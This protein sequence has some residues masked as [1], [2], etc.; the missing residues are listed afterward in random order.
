MCCYIDKLFIK[1]FDVLGRQELDKLKSIIPELII[2]ALRYENKEIIKYLFGKYSYDPKFLEFLKGRLSIEQYDQLNL[3]AKQLSKKQ[4]DL[5]SIL[6]FT[7]KE[8]VKQSLNA[9]SSKALNCNFSNMQSINELLKKTVNNSIIHPDWKLSRALLGIMQQIEKAKSKAPPSLSKELLQ[10]IQQLEYVDSR[11]FYELLSDSSLK[12]QI[13]K[14]FPTATEIGNFDLNYYGIEAINSL[15]T[16][17]ESI[18]TEQ[19]DEPLK[20]QFINEL[21]VA[22]KAL[23][24]ALDVADQLNEIISDVTEIMMEPLPEGSSMDYN[25]FIKG[26]IKL[27]NDYPHAIQAILN[28]IETF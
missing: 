27:C 17:A 24:E 2:T 8:S 23:E 5:V 6:Q 9:Q 1:V 15:I 13:K 28:R 7:I 4:Q 19:F 21:C 16:N 18:S 10:N 12:P 14:F 3:L 20:E 22:Q 26:Q 25:D 11:F